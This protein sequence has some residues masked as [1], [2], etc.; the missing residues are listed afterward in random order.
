MKTILDPCCGP[1][2]MW[3][4]PDN[5]A[6]VFGDQRC[7]QITVTDRSHGKAD[8]KRV[9]RIEPDVVMDFRAIPYPDNSFALVAFDPPHLVRAG[10]KSW[11][12]ARYGK[13]SDDW[14]EDIA[15]GFAECFRVL[16][17]TGTLVFKW[18]EIQIKLRE[19]LPLVENAPLFG[20]KS[21]RN[22]MTHWLVL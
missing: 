3:F 10:S 14:R 22:G 17:P 11:L 2:S 4:D 20:Q 13:L 18:N 9:L 19:I 15:K 1:R 16:K 5:E 6:A 12:A 8:G 7:E 21:G